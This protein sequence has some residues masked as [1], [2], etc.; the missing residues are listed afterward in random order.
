MSIT[1]DRLKKIAPEIKA[2]LVKKGDI[3]LCRGKTRKKP[4]EK[5]KAGALYTMALSRMEKYKPSK[6]KEGKVVLPYFPR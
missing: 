6:D 4:R 5:D 1:Y 3:D 2:E